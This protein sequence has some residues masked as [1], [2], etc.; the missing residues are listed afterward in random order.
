MNLD[1][2]YTQGLSRVDEGPDGEE[3]EIADR[4]LT[5]ML[6]LGLGM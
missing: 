6:G 3:I 4:G 5:L 1:G 2:R